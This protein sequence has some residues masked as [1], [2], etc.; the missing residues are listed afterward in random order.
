MLIKLN[1]KIRAYHLI[2]VKKAL[3]LEYGWLLVDPRSDLTQFL[4][5]FDII[6]IQSRICKREIK[7]SKYHMDIM[8]CPLSKVTL[9]ISYAILSSMHIIFHPSIPPPLASF[10]YHAQPETV[11]SLY[12]RLQLSSITKGILNSCHTNFLLLGDLSGIHIHT[13]LQLL[14]REVYASIFNQ[15]SSVLRKL[16]YC[17]F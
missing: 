11:S 7:S 4:T 8:P 16:H 2:Y 1:E 10:K 6:N 15:P 17:S 9:M 13:I 12:N 5:T 3:K 14:I